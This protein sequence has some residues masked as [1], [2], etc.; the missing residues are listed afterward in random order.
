MEKGGGAQH[1]CNGA[2]NAPQALSFQPGR[3]PEQPESPFSSPPWAHRPLEGVS[4][5][6]PFCLGW[7]KTEVWVEVAQD[8]HGSSAEGGGLASSSGR[9][10]FPF[11]NNSPKIKPEQK[12][13]A[14]NH[15]NIK[16][17]ISPKSQHIPVCFLKFTYV[18]GFL[19]VEHPAMQSPPDV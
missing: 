19:F 9:K 16:L 2:P 8:G 6:R 15:K 1:G 7:M 14:K 17:G 11:Q 18:G 12:R 10:R 5:R 3:T 4:V 13:P